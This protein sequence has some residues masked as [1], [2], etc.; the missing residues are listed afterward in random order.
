MGGLCC[1]QKEIKKDD[2]TKRND[3]IM[4]TKELIN[5]TINSKTNTSN[6]SFYKKTNKKLKKKGKKKNNIKIQAPLDS[7]EIKENNISEFSRIVEYEDKNNHD[8]QV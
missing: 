1:S 5:T 3:E 7:K 2:I 4:I 6:I 8:E